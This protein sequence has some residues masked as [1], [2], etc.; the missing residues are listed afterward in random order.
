M[1]IVIS[2]ILFLCCN[3]VYNNNNYLLILECNY[4]GWLLSSINLK[5]QS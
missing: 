1:E 3:K 5:K 2:P 4:L